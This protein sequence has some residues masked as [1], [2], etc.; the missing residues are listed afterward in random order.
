MPA[1]GIGYATIFGLSGAALG[2]VVVSL[3]V[4]TA[5]N[6]YLLAQRMGGDAKLMA[7]IITLQT[8]GAALTLT[9]WLALLAIV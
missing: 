8:M 6:A 9:A 7:E 5:A 2:T 3:A 1:I 4:P